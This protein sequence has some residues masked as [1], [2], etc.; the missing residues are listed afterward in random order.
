MLVEVCSKAI[1]RLLVRSPKVMQP[2]LE[3][4]GQAGMGISQVRRRSA[5]RSTRRHPPDRQRPSHRAQ[6]T[7]IDHQQIVRRSHLRDER[8]DAA[9]QVW[10][11]R[12]GGRGAGSASTG[13]GCPRQARRAQP[14]PAQAGRGKVPPRPPRPP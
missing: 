7:H 10:P 14:L 3:G 5:A 12:A 2:K 9:V 1:Q 8:Q 13:L 6:P 4:G 11:L